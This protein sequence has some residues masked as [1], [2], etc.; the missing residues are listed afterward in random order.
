M[1]LSPFHPPLCILGSLSHSLTPC[2]GCA[3]VSSVVYG[4]RHT[5]NV[6]LNQAGTARVD[7]HPEAPALKASMQ[8]AVKAGTVGSK[9]AA[10]RLVALLRKEVA[11]GAAMGHGVLAPPPGFSGVVG[12]ATM[13]TSGSPPPGFGGS[14]AAVPF[15]NRN[16]PSVSGPPLTRYQPIQPPMQA[17]SIQLFGASVP[18]SRQYDP[19]GGIA[20][21]SSSS[22]QYQPFGSRIYSLWSG[23]PGIDLGL[24]ASLW[25]GQ[26]GSLGGNGSGSFVSGVGDGRAVLGGGDVSSNQ[27]GFPSSTTSSLDPVVGYSSGGGAK[28]PPP[29]FG[30]SS[31][32]STG[33][34]T[35][36]KGRPYQPFGPASAAVGTGG[37]GGGAIGQGYN[38]LQP[39]AAAAAAAGASAA[40]RAPPPGMTQPY[41]PQTLGIGL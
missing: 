40:V 12:A 39:Q 24:G 1:D 36:A 25:Q 17:P 14:G 34:L 23:L 3:Q 31:G 38:P 19:F 28:M 30:P 26:L 29:G 13:S 20:G 9:E 27:A 22:G 37:G 2:Y 32:G 10:A 6:P 15:I 8:A 33:D 21:S 5:V 4:S 11:G 7:V 18:R 35:Q 16:D 41:R